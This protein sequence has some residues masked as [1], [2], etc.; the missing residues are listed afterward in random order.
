MCQI[1]GLYRKTPLKKTGI[2]PSFKFSHDVHFSQNA[3]Y[4]NTLGNW[5]V[6]LLFELWHG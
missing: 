4:R 1:V 2:I 3:T 5:R 6:S